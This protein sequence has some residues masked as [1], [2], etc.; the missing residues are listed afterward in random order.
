MRGASRQKE[1]EALWE[2]NRAVRK[3]LCDLPP[4]G[5]KVL[6]S[7]PAELL[8]PY[9][10]HGFP[11]PKGL[12]GPALFKCLVQL[13]IVYRDKRFDDCINAVLEHG[14]VDSDSCEF[15]DKQGPEL[16]SYNQRQ[17]DE[18]LAEV[19]SRVK[20]GVSERQA[21]R[22]VAADWGLPGNSFAAATE[23]LRCQ[24]RRSSGK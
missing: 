2:R 15:T 13:S 20:Q 3:E 10:L 16:D 11:R 22:E 24:R 6:Q 7:L 8:R 23:Q 18:C 14:I 12:R 21:C 9:K 1:L 17:V 5:T 19:R 4:A